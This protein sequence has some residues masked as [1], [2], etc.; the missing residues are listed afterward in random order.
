MKKLKRFLLFLLIIFVLIFSFRGFLYRSFVSYR[1]IGE[2]KDVPVENQLLIEKLNEIQFNSDNPDANEIILKSLKFTSS[3]LSFTTQ[4]CQIN[5][6]FL[7]TKPKTHCVGYAVF[8]ANSCNYLFKKYSLQKDWKAIACKGKLSF[9]GYDMHNIFKI[10]FFKDHDFV[11]IKNLKSVQTFAVDPSVNDY[12]FI[13]FV[14][15]KIY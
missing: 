14:K 8:Y 6:N 4:R 3:Q 5:P 7:I 11:I 15:H 13:D 1:T 10:P 12:L 9:L 2:R